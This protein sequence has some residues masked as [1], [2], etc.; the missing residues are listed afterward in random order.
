MYI[1]N[2][3]SALFELDALFGFSA[4]YSDYLSGVLRRKYYGHTRKYRSGK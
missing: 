4:A 1:P 2:Y 3:N